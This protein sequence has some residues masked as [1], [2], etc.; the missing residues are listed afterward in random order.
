M[1][2]TVL[3]FVDFFWIWF[4]VAMMNGGTSYLRS[5]A[6]KD[7]LMALKEEL[8]A[9]TAEIRGLKGEAGSEDQAQAER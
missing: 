4:I 3:T 7:D 5:P 1:S 8:A 9:L 2:S 6:D